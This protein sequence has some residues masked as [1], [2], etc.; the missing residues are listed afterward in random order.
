MTRKN[1][2]RAFFI[3]APVGVGIALVV[4]LSRSL[5]ESP[6]EKVDAARIY[7]SIARQCQAN[8]YALRLYKEASAFFD[9]A[10]TCWKKE[11]ER[12]IFFRN[13]S[14]V[15]DYADLS[16]VKSRLATSESKKIAQNLK[17]SVIQKIDS[18]NTI[19]GS[20]NDLLRKLPLTEKQ[21]KNISNGKLLLKESRIEYDQKNYLE[22]GFRAAKSENLLMPV[23]QEIRQQ[24]LT[25]FQS[26]PRW[27]KM[28]ASAIEKSAERKSTL[29]IVDKFAR[30]L[31][32]YQ[33]GKKKYTF[34]AE[35]GSNWMKP[36]L[37]KGDKA[38][39]E[40]AYMVKTKIPPG[41]T[42][43]Y[44]A[45]LLNYPNGDDMERFVREKK[46]GNLPANASIGGL[47]EIHGGGGKQTDWTD[48]C[49]ALKNEDM[50]KVYNLVNQGTPVLIV[51]SLKELDVALVQHG[52]TSYP[53][54]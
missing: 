10:M 33:A 6:F 8:R 19:I 40:G 30:Q 20:L 16:A 22:A 53:V 4:L 21:M 29:I 23:F 52:L 37:M 24:L 46:E 2:R 48:G 15:N 35:L 18:L 31:F 26:L 38:T 25:Y 45:L 50:L 47:I 34:D 28:A 42:K 17:K 32:V 1:L 41:K 27:K 12:I 13:Y 9:S 43:Y 51:G 11:N 7:L 44:R 5:P 49:I 39:P 3:S 54:L 36:K 14:K